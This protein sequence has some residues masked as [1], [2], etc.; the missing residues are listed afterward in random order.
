MHNDLLSIIV[1]G[2]TVTA[3]DIIM[4][5]YAVELLVRSQ[6]LWDNSSGIP[7]QDPARMQLFA[8]LLHA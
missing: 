3:L 7:H 1:Y 6:N 2:A 5:I 4:G 8:L